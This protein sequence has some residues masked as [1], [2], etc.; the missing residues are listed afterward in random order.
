[1]I[2]NNN[3]VTSLPSK[4]FTLADVSLTSVQRQFNAELTLDWRQTDICQRRLFTG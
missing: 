2:T 1:M 3:I 4:Q